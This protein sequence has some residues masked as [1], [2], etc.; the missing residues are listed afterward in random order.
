MSHLA[1]LHTPELI[2]IETQRRNLGREQRR[3]AWMKMNE[4]RIIAKLRETITQRIN[5]RMKEKNYGNTRKNRIER[6]RKG[7]HHKQSDKGKTK[8]KKE[9]T[10]RRK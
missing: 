10:K 1:L 6:K 7:K 9:R 4:C 3:S 8:R 5:A 2:E